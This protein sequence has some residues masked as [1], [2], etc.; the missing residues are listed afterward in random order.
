MCKLLAL[1]KFTVYAVVDEPMV[2]IPRTKLDTLSARI[3]DVVGLLPT[4]DPF[5]GKKCRS[6]LLDA[7]ELRWFRPSM[8][9]S[10]DKMK[11][12]EEDEGEKYTA[13]KSRNSP[14]L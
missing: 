4:T 1:L 6:E 13:K 14:R 7:H 9:R 3:S 10:F 5:Q 11:E 2:S 12:E 8:K